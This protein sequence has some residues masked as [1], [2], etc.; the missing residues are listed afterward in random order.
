MFLS[1]SYKLLEIKG[2]AFDL[3]FKLVFNYEYEHWILGDVSVHRNYLQKCKVS[4][5][6]YFLFLIMLFYLLENRGFVNR[7][8]Q[9]R[10]V[11]V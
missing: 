11:L 5:C 7:S 3:Y 10:I 4:Y 1:S 6:L 9:S 2:S 8:Q